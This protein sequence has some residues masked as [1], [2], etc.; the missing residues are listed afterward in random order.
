MSISNKASILAIK[1]ETTEGVPL[2]PTT[3]S[4]VVALQDGFSFTPNF[5]Q[6][7]NKELRS[8]IG[9]AKPILGLEQPKA[10]TAHYLRHSGVEGQA[11]NYRLLLKAVLG[12]EDVYG[13]Q[14]NTVSS[15]TVSTV[16]VGSGNGVNFGRGHMLM[17]KDSAN[18]YSVRPVHSVSTDDLSLGFDLPNAPGSGI[19]LGK[20]VM[21]SPLNSGFPSASFWLYRGNG[22]AVE[23]MAG[24][25]VT[26]MDIDLKAG[27]FIDANFNIEGV[28]YYF[29]PLEV[30]ST[31]KYL[32][33]LDNST[34]R[35]AIVPLGTYKDP[36]DLAAAIA[37]AMNGL[38]SSNTFT[39]KYYSSLG[40]YKITS[41]G[42]TF[43]LL[44][45]TGTNT[46]NTIGSLIGADVSADQ[47][48]ALTYTMAN[49]IA[50]TC[51]VTAA[52]DNSDPIIAKDMDVLI[53]DHDDYQSVKASQVSLKYVNS[54]KETQDITA[55]SG[56]S[57]STF[58]NREITLNF[59][60]QMEKY[61]IE[62]FRRFRNGVDTRF[63]LTAGIKAGGNWTPGK[64]V[65]IY[66]PNIQITSH[67]GGD[68]SGLAT[69]DI[70]AKVFV[71]TNGNP[72]MYLGFL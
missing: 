46:A 26:E 65:S 6:Q 18:G 41:T 68:D 42:T 11:P 7:E 64:C 21:Y 15:S 51:P 72:E 37:A 62:K 70:E 45:N 71:D 28:G 8:S 10:S 5:Q 36:D 48:S 60:I 47:T 4:D 9:K 69:L 23:M 58:T 30:T 67:Q 16:K 25:R 17:V 63:L 12:R 2:K 24:G 49:Q 3:S 13:T 61:D 39:V 59:T 50:I 54:R 35:T 43:S 20:A 53:G 22:G 34:N 52:Y 33:F 38:G 1:E 55:K 27:E 66:L 32:D 56:V 44:W 14:Y 57:G 40:K 19:G 29:N 31:N